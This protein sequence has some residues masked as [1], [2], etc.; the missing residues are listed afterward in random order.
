MRKTYKYKV[1]Q[2]KTSWKKTLGKRNTSNTYSKSSFIKITEIK[3]DTKVEYS[4]IIKN[5]CGYILS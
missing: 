5:E 1:S 3:K 4:F 2:K